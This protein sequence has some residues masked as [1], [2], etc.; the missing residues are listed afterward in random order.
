MIATSFNYH[1]ATSIEEALSLLANSD[2]GQPLAGGHS[3]IPAMKLRLNQPEDLVDITGIE[4]LKGISDE[5]DYLLAGAAVTHGA[6]ADSKAM[7]ASCPFVA[8]GAAMIGDIQVRNKGTLGGSLAHADPAADWPA[9]LLA[10]GATIR[11][12]GNKGDRKVAAADFFTGFFETALAD[13]ELIT[14]VEFPKLNANQHSAYQKC[15]QPASR[16]AIVG[17]AA[18]L[19]IDAGN[20]A[21]AS[22]AITGLSS[23]AYLAAEVAAALKGKPATAE[24]MAAAAALASKADDVLSDH[25]ASEDYRRHLATVYVR[26]ALEACL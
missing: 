4:A 16:F 8:A 23:H 9:L 6:I 11:L 21:D 2:N 17:C 22:V 1:K 26:R 5:G 25:Y 12:T 10:A 13:G 14:G 24:T 3:L 7:K 15:V 18:V 20:I 19:T